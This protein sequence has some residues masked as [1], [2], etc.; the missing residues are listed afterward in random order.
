M[1]KIRELISLPFKAIAVT[2]MLMSIVVVL[3]TEFIRGG[4]KNLELSF[5]RIDKWLDNHSEK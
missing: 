5:N 4:S 2:L 3:F 1:K